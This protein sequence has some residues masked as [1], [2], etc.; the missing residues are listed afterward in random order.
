MRTIQAHLSESREIKIYLHY[1][2]CSLKK[3][4]MFVYIMLFTLFL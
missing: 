4:K 3:Y 2:T 1:L